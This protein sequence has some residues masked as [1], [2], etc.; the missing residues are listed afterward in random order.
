MRIAKEAL[1]KYEDMPETSVD[2][3]LYVKCCEPLF[4]I[5]DL[6]EK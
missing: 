2:S 5:W 1:L 4:G 6:A 3:M